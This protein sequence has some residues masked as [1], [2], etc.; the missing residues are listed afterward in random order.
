MFKTKTW[1]L[2]MQPALPYPIGHTPQH[3]QCCFLSQTCSLISGRRGDW[4]NAK[5][6]RQGMKITAP[7]EHHSDF[8]RRQVEFVFRIWFMFYGRT[9]TQKNIFPSHVC[10]L[11][12]NSSFQLNSFFFCCN[13]NENVK[14]KNH[15][16][17]LTP[18]Q[19][20]RIQAC[21]IAQRRILPRYQDKCNYIMCVNYLFVNKDRCL[22]NFIAH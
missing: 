10:L 11:V 12:N 6:G 3:P 9:H 16:V 4:S 7:Q 14:P 1:R 15:P 8:P 13:V 17:M 19:W 2:P 22:P 20:E 18:L 21:R 5:D